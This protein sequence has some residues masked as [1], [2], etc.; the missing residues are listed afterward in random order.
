M[1]KQTGVIQPNLTKSERRE[2]A[3]LH[4]IS[5]VVRGL[6]QPPKPAPPPS[7]PKK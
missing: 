1:K 5:N 7:Q 2:H 3:N 4:G 6:A